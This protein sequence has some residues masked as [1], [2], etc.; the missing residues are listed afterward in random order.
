M[1]L[2]TRNEE[3][4][5]NLFQMWSDRSQLQSVEPFRNRKLSPCKVCQINDH[6]NV[7]Q[8]AIEGFFKVCAVDFGYR[9]DGIHQEPTDGV[10]RLLLGRLQAFTWLFEYSEP[11]ASSPDPQ[12]RG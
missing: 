8:V 11:S 3:N 12:Q 2:E 6:E 4:V 9:G 10:V 7:L 5:A 1:L